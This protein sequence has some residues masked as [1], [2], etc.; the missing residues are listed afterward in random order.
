MSAAALIAEIGDDMSQFGGM[1][2]KS[3]QHESAGKRKSG[4]TRKGNKMIKRR[5]AKWR[6]SRPRASSKVN[7][8]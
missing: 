5:C 4:R 8:R 2:E 6:T 7:I 3:G 1:K